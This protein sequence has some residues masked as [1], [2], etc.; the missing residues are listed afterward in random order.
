ML[1]QAQLLGLGFEL[2]TP[3]TVADEQEFKL[4]ALPHQIGGDPKQ[5]VV[6]FQLGKPSSFADNEVI[7]LKAKTSAK[8]KVI[9]SSEKRSQLKAAED[10]CVL[11]FSA[12]PGSEV[13]AGHGIGDDNEMGG[14]SSGITLGRTEQ[15]IGAKTLEGTEGRAVHGMDDERNARASGSNAPNDSRFAAVR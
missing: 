8:R 2:L 14:N 7:R 1:L 10:F 11:G 4:R 12:N 6:A 13:L 5:I 3:G 15:E 9:V